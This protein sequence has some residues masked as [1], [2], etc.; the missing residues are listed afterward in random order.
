MSNMEHHFERIALIGI[1]LIG[2]SLARSIN[3]HHLCEHIS[4]YSRSPAT[5]EKAGDLKLGNSY[6][7]DPA[8]AVKDADL[9]IICTPM[10]AY[11]RVAQ[12]MTS[13]LKT[14][15]IISDVGQNLRVKKETIVG[16]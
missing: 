4:I 12:A 9:V 2:S 7:E 6:H 10:G 1:G 3:K 11:T 15:A 5:L 16:L 8:E 14:G 13:G